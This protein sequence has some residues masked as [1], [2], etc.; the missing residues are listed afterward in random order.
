MQYDDYGSRI[1][2]DERGKR[3]QRRI[4]LATAAAV[5]LWITCAQQD[6][7][8]RAMAAVGGVGGDATSDRSDPC[9]ATRAG[10]DPWST[11]LEPER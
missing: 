5:A 2:E 11:P 9:G 4:W 6:R 3:A 10:E 7:G 8:G 1:Y